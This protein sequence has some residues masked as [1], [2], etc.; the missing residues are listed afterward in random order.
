MVA[1]V[2]ALLVVVKKR[3]IHRHGDQYVDGE[4]KHALRTLKRVALD[5]APDSRAPRI[6]AAQAGVSSHVGLT[7]TPPGATG[8]AG[9]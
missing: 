4:E 3:Q 1:S 2:D 7:G 8:Y 5:E 9:L 6:R